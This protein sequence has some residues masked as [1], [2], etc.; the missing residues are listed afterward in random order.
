MYSYT[1]KVY[2]HFQIFSFPYSA[3]FICI[4]QAAF[5]NKIIQIKFFS[6]FN[7]AFL[8]LLFSFTKFLPRFS[9]FQPT[10]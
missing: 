4:Q 2:T 8:L 10:E 6:F 5:E 1:E 9:H 3:H 7:I